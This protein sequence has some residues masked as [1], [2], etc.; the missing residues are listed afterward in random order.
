MLQLP[1]TERRLFGVF[2]DFFVPKGDDAG[3]KLSEVFVHVIELFLGLSD[4]SLRCVWQSLEE[5]C[6]GVFDKV[7]HGLYDNLSSKL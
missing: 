5:F 7:L 4:H 2:L 1:L 6:V 3:K